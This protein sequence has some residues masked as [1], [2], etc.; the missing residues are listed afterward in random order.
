[1]NK[2]I[3]IA[4]VVLA[5]SSCTVSGRGFGCPGPQQNWVGCGGN[6]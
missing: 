2:L 6:R 5:L 1:M 4:L 3:L